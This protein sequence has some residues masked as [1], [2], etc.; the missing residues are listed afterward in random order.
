MAGKKD[1]DTLVDEIVAV[2]EEYSYYDIADDYDDMGTYRA[3]V[4]ETLADDPEAIAAHLDM[5]AGELEDG[6]IYELAAEVRGY[7]DH[8][9]ATSIADKSDVMKQVLYN[10]G[11]ITAGDIVWSFN[12]YEW[13]IERIDFADEEAPELSKAT[14]GELAGL[15]D[16]VVAGQVDE[17]AEALAALRHAEGL[18]ASGAIAHRDA[19]DD[20]QRR[21]DEFVGEYGDDG[22]MGV[23]MDGYGF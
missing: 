1:F 23:D 22:D 14:D 19:D 2:D 7:D 12:P 20:L 16:Q 21:I 9:D 18:Y 17:P 3:Y 4:A 5:L 15:Y 13:D 6:G 11:D 8:A 10:E